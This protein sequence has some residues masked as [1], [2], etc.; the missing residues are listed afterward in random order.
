[1]T[2]VWAPWVGAAWPPPA[3][4]L[5]VGVGVVLG[6]GVAVA[7]EGLTPRTSPST[8]LTTPERIL[9]SSRSE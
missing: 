1:M 4:E 9:A 5:G 6:V 7:A 8:L 3:E 2:S